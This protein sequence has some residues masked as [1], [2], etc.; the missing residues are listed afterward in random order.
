M[1]KI[2]ALEA[3]AALAHETRLEVF[4]SL[5]QAGP[6]GLAA[7]EIATLHAV[8]QNT[9]S[10]HL[11]I[12]SRSGLITRSRAGR[13]IRY[14]ANYAAMQSLLMYLLEDCCRG[15][16]EICAPIAQAIACHC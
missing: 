11:A 2:I 7:G 10:S 4:R 13:S 9:M 5:I 6:D 3:L 16:A 12:L 8:V 1:D 14:R 15:N